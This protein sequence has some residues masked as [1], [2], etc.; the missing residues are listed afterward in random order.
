MDITKQDAFRLA[1][2]AEQLDGAGRALLRK[3]RLKALVNYARERSPYYREHYKYV[4]VDFTLTALPTTD[5]AG[6]MG[7][8][9]AWPTDSAVKK[10]EVQAFLRQDAVTRG[11]FLGKYS[12]LTT[13]GTTGEPLIMLRDAYHNQIHN[14][15]KLRRLYAALPAEMRNIMDLTKY[16]AAS[17]IMDDPRVSSYSSFLR[18]KQEAG[19]NAENLQCVSVRLPT[20]K[21]VALL[22]ELQ[23]DAVTCYPSEMVKM[24]VEQRAGRL[25]ISPKLILC[26][27]E[28]LSAEDYRLLSE[29][30]GAIILNNYCMTEGGEVAF[31]SGSPD[32]RLNDDWIIIEPVDADGN[33]VTEP[34]SWSEG[35]FVTDLSNFIQPVIRYYVND[36]IRIR[37]PES[38]D[39]NTFPILEIRGRTSR[40]IT[41]CGQE[42]TMALFEHLLENIN[43]LLFLQYVQTGP[44]AL[45]L[46]AVFSP[47]TDP[48]PVKAETEREVR[49]LLDDSGCKGYSLRWSDG[50]PIR[51]RNGGKL[52]VYIDAAGV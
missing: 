32:L 43:G 34:G 28:L 19:A 49:T 15:I 8:Y 12:V 44:D 36:Q 33:P 3:Q 5:K 9:E 46:R 31:A 14:A 30:F 24:A 21:K 29:T 45:E 10:E 22:N 40:N 13:S 37:A 35:I 23:P 6:L 39:R 41:I 11:L 1:A 2:E 27:A 4:P 50:E 42:I 16:R 52:S 51:N 38:G 18:T 26:S 17:L 25:H 48:A 7:N 20:D 47:G